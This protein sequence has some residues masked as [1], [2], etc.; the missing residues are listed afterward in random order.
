[1]KTRRRAKFLRLTLPPLLITA[2]SAYIATVD[3]SGKNITMRQEYILDNNTGEV[4]K[5]LFKRLYCFNFVQF[6]TLCD[7]LTLPIQKRQTRL[8]CRGAIK[9]LATMLCVTLL[10]LAADFYLDVGWP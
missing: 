3:L 2:I 7:L 5:E 9:Y 10:I 6:E 8:S 1:M 4:G